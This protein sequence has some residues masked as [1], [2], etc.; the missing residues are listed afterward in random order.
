MPDSKSGAQTRVIGRAAV[1]LLLAQQETA[2]S[3]FF[4][5]A[6]WG[7]GHFIGIV[8]DRVCGKA[9]LVDVTLPTLHHTFASVAEDLGFS[10]LTIAALFGHSARGVTEHYVRIDEALQMAA[11]KVAE[12][13]A[14]FSIAA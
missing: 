8:R 3:P 13:I 5:P 14:P 6:D 10:E 11:N 7:E 12:Q 2:K 4:F 1:D 9:G